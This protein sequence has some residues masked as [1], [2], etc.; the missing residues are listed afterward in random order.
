LVEALSIKANFLGKINF[1]RNQTNPKRKEKPQDGNTIVVFWIYRNREPQQTIENP[2]TSLRQIY[3]TGLRRAN[4]RGSLPENTKVSNE[5]EN[6]RKC[7]SLNPIQLTECD[8]PES[9]SQANHWNMARS[10]NIHNLVDKSQIR[11][12]KTEEKGI[13]THPNSPRANNQ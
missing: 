10:I 8:E 1:F 5:N 9:L 7:D 13:Q 6:I 11:E 2:H 12:P 4:S 3:P